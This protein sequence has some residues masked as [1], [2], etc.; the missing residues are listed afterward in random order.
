MPANKKIHS[1]FK[2]KED[3]ILHA[4][5]ILK[6]PGRSWYHSNSD[7][8]TDDAKKLL[9]FIMGSI[10]KEANYT[11]ELSK[12][13]GID[14]YNTEQSIT[15]SFVLDNRDDQD[16]SS[17]QSRMLFNINGSY[18]SLFDL[19]GFNDDDVIKFTDNYKHV[20]DILKISYVHFCNKKNYEYA[21]KILNILKGPNETYKDSNI[22]LKSYLS[23]EHIP[24]LKYYDAEK[25]IDKNLIN[26]YVE[27]LY[28]DN[29]YIEEKIDINF[30]EYL[31]SKYKKLFKKVQFSNNLEDNEVNYFDILESDLS[32]RER[33]LRASDYQSHTILKNLASKDP[34]KLKKIIINFLNFTHENGKRKSKFISTFRK[35]KNVF[36]YSNF[37]LDV[38]QFS[39]K[40]QSYILL[41]TLGGD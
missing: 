4:N 37:E 16:F 21:T 28:A 13:L 25:K 29:K 19:A 23:Y 33:I 35:L 11:I 20:I 31:I 14:S 17:M 22:L 40:L 27:S 24:L 32:A 39:P 12:K 8:L 2:N 7:D 6:K 10:G 5:T 18:H 3:A 1:V 34:E 38:F 9:K 26:N 30:H 15:L 36:R 41:E